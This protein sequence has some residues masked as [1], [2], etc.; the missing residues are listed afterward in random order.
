MT[1]LRWISQSA[2]WCSRWRYL[3]RTPFVSHSHYCCG[4]HSHNN[5][6]LIRF[7]N[8]SVRIFCP[9]ISTSF[10]LRLLFPSQSLHRTYPELISCQNN[11]L[12]FWNLRSTRN[13][14]AWSCWVS[15]PLRSWCCHTVPH[16]LY[17]PKESKLLFQKS[18]F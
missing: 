3:F 18:P 11:P 4:L 8:L 12:T 17:S 2:Y 5:H 16:L 15:L 9:S 10:S 14:T 7:P 6:V 1:R 13:R